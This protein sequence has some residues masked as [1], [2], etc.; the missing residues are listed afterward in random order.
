MLL[1]LGEINDADDDG[2]VRAVDVADSTTDASA[3]VVGV[4][5]EELEITTPPLTRAVSVFAGICNAV[6]AAL[7]VRQLREMVQ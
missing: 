7:I 6:A 1:A 4:S 5:V 2:D 3:L